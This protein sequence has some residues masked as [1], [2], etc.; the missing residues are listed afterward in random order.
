M[1]RKSP[2]HRPEKRNQKTR[3]LI[4][5]RHEVVRAGVRALLEGEQDLEVVGE[6]HNAET[7]FSESRR[8]KPDVILLESGLAGGSEF[9]IYKILFH[10]LPSIRIVSLMRDDDIEAFRDAVT[11]G[12]QGYLG[13]KT[14]RTELIRAIRTVAKG[15]SYLGHETADQTFHLL[16]A[17]RD[18]VCIPSALHILSPQE[19]RV[20]ALIAEGDT[21][22]GIAAKLA[23]SEKTVKNYIVSIFVKLKIERRTQA[24]ALYMKAQKHQ[25]SVCEEIS[26]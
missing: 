18:P 13:E 6:A 14:G 21:N 25:N 11:A 8:T 7:V 1:R 22:K 16:R 12:V 26:A 10:V 23:L 4:A 24:A 9:D 2:G 20:I 3:V 17:R 5:D 15:S 19:R